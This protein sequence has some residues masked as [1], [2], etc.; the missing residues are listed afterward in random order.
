MALI[1]LHYVIQGY[2][3]INAPPTDRMFKCICLVCLILSSSLQ[4]SDMIPEILNDWPFTYISFTMHIPH[5]IESTFPLFLHWDS[6]FL[7][8][9]PSHL[10]PAHA[11]W[12]ICKSEEMPHQVLMGHNCQSLFASS[13][14]NTV[15]C[16]YSYLLFM[17]YESF[18]INL[19]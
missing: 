19:E 13:I 8:Y 9:W 2:D 5:L 17:H 7:W 18:H 10:H 6:L 4:P 14:S 1:M 11:T 15:L 16:Y 12:W 3:L